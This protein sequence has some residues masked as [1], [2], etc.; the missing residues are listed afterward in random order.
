M[1]R[2]TETTLV[3]AVVLLQAQYH[4]TCE[5]AG[6]KELVLVRGCLAGKD[7]SAEKLTKNVLVLFKQ[8]TT[9]ETKILEVLPENATKET[10][11]LLEASVT[12]S[13]TEERFTL[14]ALEG[15]A[16]LEKW[17]KDER[18]SRTKEIEVLLMTK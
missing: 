8:W 7:D 13:A 12:S 5:A 17:I 3:S 11:C 2:G 18:E 4:F 14:A 10:S 1:T 15:E 16:T 6:I 9:G